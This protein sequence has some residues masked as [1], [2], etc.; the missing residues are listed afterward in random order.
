MITQISGDLIERLPTKMVVWVMGG[1][2]YEIIVPL[3]TSARIPA[4]ARSV[5]LYTHLQIREDAHVLYG[6]GTKEEREMFRT[7]IDNVAGVGPKIALSVLNG[8]EIDQI[9]IAVSVGDAKS[10]QVSGVGAK[11]AERICME[12]KGKVGMANQLLPPGV[13]NGKEAEVVTDAIAALRALGFKAQDARDA[14]SAAWKTT[15]ANATVDQ[16]VRAALKK[17]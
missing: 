5:M 8:L 9:K 6:F 1:V 17:K 4:D 12:L 14:V 13:G 10:L 11:L 16:V 15:G 3:S 7:L 2:G